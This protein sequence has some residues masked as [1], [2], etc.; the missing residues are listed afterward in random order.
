MFLPTSK[1][2]MNKR[3]WKQLDI[4]L[5]TGDAYVD[6]PSFGTS[7]IGRYL[8]SLNYKVGI[9]AQP[10]IKNGYSDFKKLGKPKLFWGIS[11]GNLDSIVA[12][13][14]ARRKVRNDDSYSNNGRAFYEDKKGEKY[15]YRPD[16][17]V[18][19]Y[20]QIVKKEFDNPKIVLGGIEASLRRFSHYDYYQ[21]KIRHSILMDT[22]ADILVYGMGEKA[23]EEIS[24]RVKNKKSLKGI[25]GTVIMENNIEFLNNYVKL[26]NNK[27][28]KKHK[29]SLIN[30]FNILIEN[31]HYKN[32]KTLVEGDGPWYIIQYPPQKPLSTEEM[33]NLYNL[34][35]ER[36]IH[37]KYDRIPAFDM[38]KNSITSHR[39]CFG[40]CNFCSIGIHQGKHISSRSE[41]SIINEVK[42]IKEKKYFKGHIT[43]IGGPSADMYNSYCSEDEECS[44]K[45][46][47]YPKKCKFLVTN[48]KEYINLLERVNKIVNRVSIGSGLRLDMSMKYPSIVKKVI[49]KFTSGYLNIAPEHISKNVLKY[50]GKFKKGVF[51]NFVRMS[52]YILKNC[53]TVM[54]PYF[55]VGHPGEN[56]KDTKDLKSFI[57]KNNIKVDSVQE[58]VPT[59]MTYST[60]L[61]YANKD[62]N[63]INVYK[64]SEKK[65]AKNEVINL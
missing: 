52:K 44:R 21:N 7:L 24:Y 17:A 33:D 14:T 4:I 57:R 43:D 54:K 15:R 20:S 41:E 8:E 28:I 18:M 5:I 26:P 3:G 47:I 42:K 53:S 60:A 61:Y 2:D 36:A 19:K 56:F 39:G 29:K 30:R 16:R 49:E 65:K 12:N 11:S 9:I 13:Y 40:G 27:K 45:S 34:P 6:H 46:C 48:E 32:G 38:I 22:K 35:F 50:M 31:N 62:N 37:P 63:E 1:K 23:I 55:I 51:E 59:P 10:K 58:F 25:N 64:P